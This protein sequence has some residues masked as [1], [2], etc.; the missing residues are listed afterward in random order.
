[1]PFIILTKYKIPRNKYNKKSKTCLGKSLNF[2]EIH[3]R[4][5]KWRGKL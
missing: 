1:M 5:N 2:S 3:R 4:S